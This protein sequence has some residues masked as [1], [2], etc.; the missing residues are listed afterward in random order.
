MLWEKKKKAWPQKA[1]AFGPHQV[2]YIKHEYDSDDNHHDHT[3]W[4]E[5]ILAWYIIRVYLMDI[6]F[7]MS[8]N[9]FY[10]LNFL[11]LGSTVTS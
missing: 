9:L 3:T 8:W 1:R 10:E 11:Y 6:P 5:K 4:K 7:H 2:I